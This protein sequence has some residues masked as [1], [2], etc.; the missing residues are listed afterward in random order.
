MTSA[1]LLE[2]TE[3]IEDAI[4]GETEA[5]SQVDDEMGRKEDDDGEG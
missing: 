4:A 3:D 1:F 2:T 5:E